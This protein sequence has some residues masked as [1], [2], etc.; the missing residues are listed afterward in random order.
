MKFRD[1]LKY[2]KPISCYEQEMRTDSV[3]K[4]V[5]EC[6]VDS[7]LSPQLLV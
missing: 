5:L 4:S 6:Y 7:L 1:K 3:C 2:R